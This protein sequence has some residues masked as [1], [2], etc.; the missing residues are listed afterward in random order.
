MLVPPIFSFLRLLT[1]AREAGS[2]LSTPRPYARTEGQMERQTAGDETEIYIHGQTETEGQREEQP[3]GERAG[4]GLARKA[5]FSTSKTLGRRRGCEGWTPGT[6]QV[7]TEE[8]GGRGF[9]SHYGLGTWSPL[10][11]FG[12]YRLGQDPFLLHWAT[13]LVSPKATELGGETVMGP[14]GFPELDGRRAPPCFRC[15]WFC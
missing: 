15:G 11:I 1:A 2:L 13:G 8:A 14:G 7:G 12:R 10:D 9:G 6:H 4:P 5:A 3:G